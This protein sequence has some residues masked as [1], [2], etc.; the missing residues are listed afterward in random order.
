MLNE[1]EIYSKSS[2]MHLWLLGI[3]FTNTV[4]LICSRSIHVLTDTKKAQLLNPL[5]AAENATLP[6]ELHVKDKTDKNKANYE[7]LIKAIKS[8]HSGAVA[9]SLL[10]EKPQGEFTA[11]WRAALQ[12]ADGLQLVELSPALAQVLAVKDTDEQVGACSPS[13]QSSALRHPSGANLHPSRALLNPA[14]ASIKRAAIFSAEL[15]TKHLLPK[16]ETIIDEE[17]KVSHEKLAE[18]AEE[19]FGDPKKIGLNVRLS[20]TACRLFVLAA[21]DTALPHVCAC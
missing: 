10:K 9:A 20:V 6:L 3:E 17:S 11:L 18:E 7:V 1:E 12:A 13:C 8:S 4:I 16:I 15:L 19:A 5:K 21:Y 2:A 14:Q